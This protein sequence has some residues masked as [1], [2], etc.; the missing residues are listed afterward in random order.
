MTIS[1][2]SPYAV[3]ITGTVTL[4]F[5]SSVGGDDQDIVFTTAAGG[6]TA[7][8]TI[9]AGATT[10]S[11]SGNC[12]ASASNLCFDTGTVA[13]TITLT[14]DF[15]ASGTDITPSPA[16]AATYTTSPTV[17]SIQTVTLEQTPGG[18]TVLVTGLSSTRD[19]SS[20]AFT[21]AAATGTTISD[22]TVNV[23]LSSAFT[24]WYSNTASNAYGSQFTL[25]MPFPV[26][27]QAGDLVSV[28]VTLTNSKGTSTSVS[29][30]Q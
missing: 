9:P 21:F 11:F 7:S 20:G 30:T 28:T 24:T 5:Q 26:S 3:N 18:V 13:G 14:L 4:T 25:T 27:G 16:P 23:P 10:A 2:A 15:M 19:M 1:I 12:T 22:P 8:F 6:R 29:P 17:P